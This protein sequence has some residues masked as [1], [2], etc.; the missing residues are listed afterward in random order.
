MGRYAAEGLTAV[1][2]ELNHRPHKVVGR[3]TLGR[4]FS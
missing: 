1:A 4:R 3:N 2:A